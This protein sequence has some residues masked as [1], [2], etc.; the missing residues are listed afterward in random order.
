MNV[1]VEA[2]TTSAFVGIATIIATCLTFA[3]PM[4]AFAAEEDSGGISAIL[5]NMTEFIPMLVAFIILAI[6]L[7]KFGW[8]MYEGMIDR[9]AAQIKDD[10]DKA[11]Q[12]R[13]ESERILAEYQRE[14]EDAKGEAA[15]IVADAKKSAEA[16]AAAIEADA[17]AQY[18]AKLAKADAEI[19]RKT[20]EAIA[21]LQ[22]SVADMSVSVASRV[23]GEDLSDDEHRKIIERYVD[24][25]GSFNVN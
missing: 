2:K 16:S 20:Q 17:Q 18:D 13:E 23:I 12:N 24:E 5:P 1:K 22:G 8:P 19:E 15:Q 4:F 6:V 7:W 14:L 10:L 25:A 11:E 21:T 3:C 9:R